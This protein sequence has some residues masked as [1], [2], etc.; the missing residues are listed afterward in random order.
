MRILEHC[1]LSAMPEVQ[2]Q[3]NTLREAFSLDTTKPFE[4]KPT[5]GL[6]S[7]ALE[8]NSSLPDSQNTS[9][10]TSAP[11]HGSTTWSNMLD[12]GSSKTLSPASEY[13]QHSDYTRPRT[14]ASVHAST[15][16]ELTQ[17][18]YALPALHQVNSAPQIGYALEPIVSHEQPTPVW[19]PSGIFNQWNT[20]FGASSQA[21]PPPQAHTARTHSTSAPFTP[22]QQPATGPPSV[23]HS[24]QANQNTSSVFPG[25]MPSVPTVTPVMWQDA[26]TNAYVSGH[27]HKRYRQETVE[28]S[29]YGHYQKRRG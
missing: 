20:A 14:G 15:Y 23:Y 11:V 25:N 18:T 22:Q 13:S 9:A 5:L 12:A 3:I 24:Q 7:P 8:H 4:L 16:P 6:R 29:P 19:D 10:P 28:S 27:G 1:I 17:A 21:V 26:F 2:I